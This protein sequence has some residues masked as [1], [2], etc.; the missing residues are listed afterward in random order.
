[1][2]ILIVILLV[3]VSSFAS[4]REIEAVVGWAKPPYIVQDG[5]SG[6][7]IELVRQV[8]ASLGHELV[9]VFVP[10][11]RSMRMM[12][13]RNAEMGLTMNASQNID[14]AILSDPYVTYQNVAVSL[15]QR[16]LQIESLSDLK[17]LSVIAFQTASQ[18]LGPEFSRA[19]EKTNGYLE[20]PEQYRQ[21]RMLLL[22][23]VDVAVM[24]I[25]IFEHFKRQ[26]PCARQA[27][28]TIHFLFDAIPYSAAIRDPVL[29]SQ[30]NDV[31]AQFKADGRYQQLLDR[32]GL[33]NQVELQP[34][35]RGFAS[36]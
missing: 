10:Y 24:D 11:G 31:L 29:R 18:V 22:G 34:E 13:D 36:L 19:V 17:G 14:L 25:N 15:K 5:S 30:F 12:E 16:T 7:E 23:S 9:P 32:F 21:V 4:S 8:L 3:M 33:I 35:N 20:V 27:Q 2:R 6:F 26:M 1:M 28:T